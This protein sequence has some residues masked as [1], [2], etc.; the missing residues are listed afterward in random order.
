MDWSREVASANNP[1]VYSS[2]RSATHPP[3]RTTR[4]APTAPSVASHNSARVTGSAR[5]T[6][7]VV[8]RAQSLYNNN[9]NN[10]NNDDDDGATLVPDSFSP[11]GTDQQQSKF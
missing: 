7:P 2:S 11:G 8:R 9:Y 3:A 4:P 6:E 1:S 5:I 10:N